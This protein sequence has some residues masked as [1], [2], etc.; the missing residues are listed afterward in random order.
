MNFILLAH[1][2]GRFGNRLH[3]YAYGAYYLKLNNYIFYLPSDWEGSKI[4]KNQYHQVIDNEDIR[5]GI[6]QSLPEY[7]NIEHRHKVITKF[8]PEAQRIFPDGIDY[9]P[10]EKKSNYLYFDNICAYNKNIFTP[11]SRKELKIMFEFNDAVKNLDI[12]KR[13]EDIQ[14]TY[15]IAHLRRD[16]LVNIENNKNPNYDMGYS[17]V[18]LK[19]YYDAFKEYDCDPDKIEWVSDD[20]SKKWH[21]NRIENKRGGWHYPVGSLEVEGVIFDWLPD[22]LRIYFA[23]KIFRANSSFSFWASCLSPNGLIFSPRVN[24]RFIYG[25]HGE[26]ELDVKF[27]KGNSPHWLSGCEFLKDIIIK[28]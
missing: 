4:F 21:K 28:D 3:Q 6:N 22:F 27:E 1:W 18:S 13:Y 19:S 16:D 23:R 11:M 9:D 17:V 12:Y 8:Y 7:D 2:N 5:Y 26:K 24:E 15:D 10:Y 14:G 25:R 20:Y